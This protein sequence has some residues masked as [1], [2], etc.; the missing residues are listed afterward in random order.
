VLL[1]F[2]GDKVLAAG[3]IACEVSMVSG[4]HL[5]SRTPKRA[6]LP[7]SDPTVPILDRPGHEPVTRAGLL[8]VGGGLLGVM[9]AVLFVIVLGLAFGH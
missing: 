4:I 9:G 8:R 5:V 6:P 1:V 3:L 7:P 2:V